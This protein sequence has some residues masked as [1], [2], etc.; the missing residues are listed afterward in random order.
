MPNNSKLV[1]SYLMNANLTGPILQLLNTLNKGK[2]CTTKLLDKN[3]KRLKR[4]HNLL[5]NHKKRKTL[6]RKT[7]PLMV[8]AQPKRRKRRKTKRKIFNELLF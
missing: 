8:K 3:Q 7:K 2:N 6:R 1:K 4:N 5:H